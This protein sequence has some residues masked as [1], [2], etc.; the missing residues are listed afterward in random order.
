MKV[1]HLPMSKKIS[2]VFILLV[3][4]NGCKS[5]IDV[6]APTENLSTTTPQFE[7][8]STSSNNPSMGNL[9]DST[10]E[11]P[12][13][14]ET[15]AL[16]MRSGGFQVW[17][18]HLSQAASYLGNEGAYCVCIDPTEMQ[19]GSHYAVF[20]IENG[21]QVFWENHTFSAD[22]ILLG[23]TVHVNFEYAAKD[24]TVVITHAPS[25]L[26]S[27]GIRYFHN[28][29]LGIHQ[30]LVGI[31]LTLPDGRFLHYPI[32]L[33]LE[34]G[35][36]TDL[37][38]NTSLNEL[39][40]VFSM[41]TYPIVP[42]GAECFLMAR[43][44]P[45]SSYSYFFLDSAE[46]KI[47]DLEAVSGKEISD[48]YHYER[49]IVCWNNTGEFWA[50]NLDNWE[51][52]ELIHV[53]N[54]EFS[55]GIFHNSGDQG[56][57]FFLYRDESHALHL[58]NFHTRE[59]SLVAEPAGWKFDSRIFRSWGHGRMLCVP[60]GNGGYLNLDS[61]TCSFQM[62]EQLP[63]DLQLWENAAPEELVFVSDDSMEYYFCNPR[64]ITFI[65]SE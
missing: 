31:N 16:S 26:T 48:G 35:K 50:I 5:E 18:V 13:V 11:E 29:S 53:P 45:N 20:S 52:E 42:I 49:E 30:V 58:F 3:A 46:G 63:P 25:G 37:L 28:T 47:V 9:T 39:C 55:N 38:S 41:E 57:S 2:L 51:T 19:Q 27:N 14:T 65:F 56:S 6:T 33:D 44:N 10:S 24:D 17:P 23:Q 43:Q 1:L 22:I 32:Y 21:E 7:E 8:S 64:D 54:V 40:E 59:D 60:T 15:Q 34:T 12:S 61:D 36:V 62:I 4:L